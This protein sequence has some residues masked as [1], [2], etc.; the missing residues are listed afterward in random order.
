MEI[1]IYGKNYLQG[2]GF[3]LKSARV[4]CS[5]VFKSTHVSD[6]TIC[7]TQS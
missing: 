5:D 7:H 1:K 4:I 3:E 2:A 6:K